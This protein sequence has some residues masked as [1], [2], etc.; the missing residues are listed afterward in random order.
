VF[1]VH[2]GKGEEVLSAIDRE[3]SRRDIQNAAITL[4]GA[5]ERCTV[6]V[7]PRVTRLPTYSLTTN[8]LSS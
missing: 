8:S 2:V 4:I 5:I 1:V 3:A 6:S 7:M